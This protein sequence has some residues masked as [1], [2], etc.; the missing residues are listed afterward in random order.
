M[1]SDSQ[2]SRDVGTTISLPGR[3][4]SH[5]AT[6][7][8]QPAAAR[9]AIPDRNGIDAQLSAVENLRLA[10][11]LELPLGLTVLSMRCLLT[12]LAN[13]YSGQREGR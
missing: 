8:R 13:L 1:R 10:T 11:R 5:R 3:G 7:D 6:R 4:Q 9:T 2:S 12:K